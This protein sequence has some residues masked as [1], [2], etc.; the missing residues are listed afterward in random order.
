VN[1]NR[2]KILFLPRW[3]P[4]RYDPMPGLFIRQQA[5][6]LTGSCDVTVLYLHEDPDCP[7]RYEV[8]CCEEN[9]VKV[10]RVYF[11]VPRSGSFF[12]K[13][14]KLHRFLKAFRMG[15]QVLNSDPPD[16][17]HVHVLTRTALPALYLKVR[18]RI[19]YLV[20]EHWSRYF[21]ENNTYKGVVRKFMTKLIVQK[22][23]GVIVV[24]EALKQAMLVHHLINPS[25]YIVSNGVD[26]ATFSLP[27]NPVTPAKRS[28]LHISCFEERSKN[29]TGF[30]DAIK[31]LSE[32]RDDFTATLIGDGPD[33]DFCRE[34]AKNMNLKDSLIKFV[35]LKMNEEVA[36]LLSEADLF[37]LSSRYETF[38]TVVIESLACGT[39]VVATR[40]GVVPEVIIPENG[41]IVE[42]GDTDALQQAID[43]V[44]TNYDSYN[45]VKI[46]AT[47]VENFSNE[48]MGSRL[49]EIYRLHLQ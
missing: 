30:L 10:V 35:G 33:F 25:Y 42:P 1:E 5:E 3:Y 37:V 40:V 31:K 39:P 4:N 16:L 23:A 43:R 46:R 14:L 36:Q 8:D 38:G 9:R 13:I 41:I 34:Y 12:V 7:N 47:V 24:S 44:L 49:L 45:R 48:N 29:I 21:P 11:R 32:K 6:S 26:M 19:P 22:A 17:I 15:Y 18:K 20:S 2:L 27:K 28:I